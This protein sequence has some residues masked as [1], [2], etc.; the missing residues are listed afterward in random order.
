MLVSRA[1]EP[2]DWSAAREMV[3]ERRRAGA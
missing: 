3:G 1:K 2:Q